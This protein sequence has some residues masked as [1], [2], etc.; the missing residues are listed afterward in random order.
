MTPN[1]CRMELQG[2]SRDLGEVVSYV[3]AAHLEALPP[4]VLPAIDPAIL[5]AEVG[6]DPEVRYQLARAQRWA[7]A[8]QET[9]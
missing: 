9:R 2:W 5:L 6:R 4:H 7:V 3:L 1:D 8:T